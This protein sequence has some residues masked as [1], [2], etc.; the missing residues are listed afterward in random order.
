M[1]TKQEA[2]HLIEKIDN[3]Y[4]LWLLH[5]VEQNKITPRSSFFIGDTRE[6]VI[7]YCK[8]NNFFQNR[9]NTCHI[10]TEKWTR[11]IPCIRY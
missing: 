4:A 10:Q 3:R 2:V 9:N 7:E 6:Y 8:K 5:N 11:L 1:Q